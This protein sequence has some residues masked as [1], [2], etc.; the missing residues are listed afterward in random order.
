MAEENL[1]KTKRKILRQ[2]WKPHV[3]LS[4]LYRIW[5]VIFGAAKIALGAIATVVLICGVCMLV[6]L[7]ILGDYLED[8]IAPLAGV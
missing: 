2:D 4:I 3:S 5:M 8:D 7:S 6:F 1:N